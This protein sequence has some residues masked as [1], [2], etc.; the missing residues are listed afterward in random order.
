MTQLIESFIDITYEIRSISSNFTSDNITNFE[1]I[2]GILSNEGLLA[3]LVNKTG[4]SP[5]NIN[6]TIYSIYYS[7]K[8]IQDVYNYLSSVNKDNRPLETVTN[9]TYCGGRFDN[10]NLI[11]A[12]FIPALIIIII[13]SFVNTRLWKRG[14]CNGRPGLAIPVNLL[15]SYEDRFTYSFAFAA[16]ASSIVN[17]VL[18]NDF[19]AVFGEDFR[20]VQKES[21]SYVNAILRIVAALVVGVSYYPFFACI[22]THQRL[23]GAVLGTIFST[24]WYVISCGLGAWHP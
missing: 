8:H 20:N 13:L 1:L 24:I 4:L 6:E 18:N 14:C 7:A 17:I 9:S 10:N 22:S 16:T 15:D 12:S 23:L 5:K 21:P 2:E 19:T 11:I 3:A